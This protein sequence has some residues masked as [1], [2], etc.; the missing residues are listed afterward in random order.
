LSLQQPNPRSIRVKKSRKSKVSSQESLNGKNLKIKEWKE[1][2]PGSM[3]T[4]EVGK[5]MKR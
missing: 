4:K 1:K 2:M 3:E 5:R